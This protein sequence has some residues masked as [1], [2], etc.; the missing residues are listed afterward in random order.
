LTA[1]LTAELQALVKE[2]RTN[3]T[4]IYT[5][6]RDVAHYRGLLV[7]LTYYSLSYS[8]A[9]AEQAVPLGGVRPA[10][11]SRDGAGRSA[12]RGEHLVEVRSGSG[13]GVGVDQRRSQAW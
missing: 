8:S 7:A 1:K 6:I 9:A 12:M 5:Q 10:G 13:L 3:L 4:A 2:I 11:V